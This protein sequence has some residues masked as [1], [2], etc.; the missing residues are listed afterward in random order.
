MGTPDF[1]VECLDVLVKSDHSIVAVVT[2][3]DKQAGRGQKI[4]TSDVK[5]YSSKKNLK[6]LQPKNLK[7]SSFINEIKNLNPDI[8]I[9]VAFRMLPKILW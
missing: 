3:E 7:D 6:I 8:F 2:S 4:K 5:D 1:A 9:V